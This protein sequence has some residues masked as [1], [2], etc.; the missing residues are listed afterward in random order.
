M[1][2]HTT[3]CA[4]SELERAAN[5]A[6]T[7]NNCRPLPTPAQSVAGNYKMGRAFV[8]G[9]DVRIENVRGSVRSGT[10]QDGKTWSNRMAAHY[11]YIAG[12]RG[13]DGDAVD[14][15]VGPFPESA[16]AWVINQRDAKGGFDEHKVMVGFATE[17]QARNGYLN[18]YDTCSRLARPASALDLRCGL[19]QGLVD[20]LGSVRVA[21]RFHQGLSG[22][23]TLWREVHRGSKSSALFERIFGLL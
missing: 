7:G 21:V 10:G 9:L 11:G 2:K 22:L 8:Q 14:I 20:R 6:A 5:E 19:D 4:F 3:P 12:T 15:F 1:H 17:A 18:S 13:A 16:S 23:V